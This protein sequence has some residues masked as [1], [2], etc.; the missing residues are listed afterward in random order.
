MHFEPS[1]LFR[2]NLKRSQSVHWQAV[3]MG[4]QGLMKLIADYAPS[5]M[6]DLDIKNYFGGFSKLPNQPVYQ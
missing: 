5:A 6:K 2:A 4:I 1:R 3:R